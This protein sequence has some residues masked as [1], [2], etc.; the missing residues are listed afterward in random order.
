MVVPAWRAMEPAAF[1]H[2]FAVYGPVTGA[3]VFPFAVAAVLLLAITTYSAVKRHRPGRLAW[4]LA[5]L[6]MAGTFVL[7]PLYF[8][9]ANLAMLDPGFPPQAVSAE[10]T[11]WYRWN[12]VRAGLGP[13]STALAC[14]AL[15]ASRGQ[16]A[17]HRGEADHGLGNS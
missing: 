16:N 3:T 17:T 5:T 13:A 7:L 10:L 4:A 12:W 11:D 1:L 8:V 15:T 14:T 9:D 2:H 6:C